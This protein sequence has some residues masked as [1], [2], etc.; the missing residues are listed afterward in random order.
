MQDSVKG[1]LT[2]GGTVWTMGRM[3]IIIYGWMQRGVTIVAV[4]VF[5]IHRISV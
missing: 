4:V 5:I 3:A 2:T 1:R